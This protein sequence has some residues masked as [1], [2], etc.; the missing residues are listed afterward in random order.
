MVFLGLLLFLDRMVLDD[1]YQG[2]LSPQQ[3]WLHLY[4]KILTATYT[5]DSEII[6]YVAGAYQAALPH[7]STP[8]RLRLVTDVYY[9]LDA[10]GIQY[11]GMMPFMFNDP[12]ISVAS[13]AA[14]NF[15]QLVPLR[16][17]D[18]MTGP[19]LLM[20]LVRSYSQN[21]AYEEQVA[22]WVWGLLALGDR[23]ILPILR[24]VWEILGPVGLSELTNAN[25]KLGRA[26]AAHVDF[27]LEWLEAVADDP[28]RAVFA[29]GALGVLGNRA[30]MTGVFDFER[31][32]PAPIFEP[33]RFDPRSGTS[34][35]GLSEPVQTN[36]LRVLQRWTA[37]EYGR[38]VEQ[39]L[40]GLTVPPPA[41]VVVDRALDAWR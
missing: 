3:L 6:Q 17:G 34:T 16:D 32:L 10:D 2:H 20:G 26:T 38:I 36:P 9:A 14:L 41:S 21:D 33:P 31:T 12:D 30:K 35:L 18:P 7:L 13:T 5:N 29:A 25:T 27:C 8:E 28:K 40:R 39:R 24:G 4:D 15:A 23:R 1:D 37:N 11:F 22:A 19:K